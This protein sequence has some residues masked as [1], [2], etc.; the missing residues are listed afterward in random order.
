MATERLF[1][2]VL[3]EC[4]DAKKTGALFVSVTAESENLIRFYFKDGE[5]IHLNYGPIN[6]R[7]CLDILDCYDLNKAVFFSSHKAPVTASN[8]PKTMSIIASIK[9]SGKKVL[10]GY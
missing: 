3:Q 5:I 4:H 10:M 1:A 2:D 9:K 7:E 8:L 6:D